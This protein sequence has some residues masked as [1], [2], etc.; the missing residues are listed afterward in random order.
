MDKI[1]KGKDN[2][3]Q[4]Q[5]QARWRHSLYTVKATLIL[6]NNGYTFFAKYYDDTYPRVKE[7]GPLE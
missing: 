2:G 3:Y 6:D 1:R 7:Q 5:L 4:Q